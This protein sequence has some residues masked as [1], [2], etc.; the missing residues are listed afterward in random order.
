MFVCA[1][2]MKSYI[3]IYI[4]IYNINPTELN[5]LQNSSGF[6]CL[7]LLLIFSCFNFILLKYVNQDANFQTGHFCFPLNPK[8]CPWNQ[9]PLWQVLKDLP[10]RILF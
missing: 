10:K 7:F 9:N 3:Y 4:Y 5:S 1:H 8:L 2:I 6:K